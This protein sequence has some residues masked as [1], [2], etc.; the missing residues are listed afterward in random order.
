[1]ADKVNHKKIISPGQV[2]RMSGKLNENSGWEVVVG[3]RDSSGLPKYLR[4]YAGA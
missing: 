4:E 2:A 3:P 1:M